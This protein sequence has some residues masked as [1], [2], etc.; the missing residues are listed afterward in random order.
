MRLFTCHL[1]ISY[2]PSLLL[3][4]GSTISSFSMCC[5]PH[6][7]MQDYYCRPILI[8]NFQTYLHPWVLLEA[9]LAK[10]EDLQEASLVLGLATFLLPIVVIL[11]VPTV[12]LSP[13]L[14]HVLEAN[15]HIIP[16]F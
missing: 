13:L 7:A 2:Y 10:A 15:R 5:I 14:Y 12:V 6:H 9:L 8:R 4:V 3:L 1:F 16:H 11:E